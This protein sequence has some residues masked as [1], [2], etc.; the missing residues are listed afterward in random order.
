VFK[1]ESNVMQLSFED[2]VGNIQAIRLVKL[3]IH[4]AENDKFVRIPD[5][6]F[7]GP[8]GHGKTTLARIVAKYLD[9]K[10]IEINATIVRDP[11]QFR[12]YIVGPNAPQTGAIIFIDECH[13]LKNK[14]QT[15]LLSATENPRKL[16]TSYK[17]QIYRDS[18]PENISFIFA[19]TKRSQIISE[20]AG[21]LETVE[22]LEYSEDEKCEMVVKYMLRQHDITSTQLNGECIVD[23]ASRSREA[24]ALVKNCDKIIL[25]MNKRGRQ[26]TKEIVDETFEILGIDEFGLNRLDRKLLKLLASCGT[27]IGIETLGDLMNMPK[28][29]IKLEIEPYLLVNNFMARRSAGRMITKKGLKTVG[30]FNADA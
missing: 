20:L 24:R 30:T 3:L 28:R 19:T 23:I 27:P 25:N 6:A 13:A 12:S 5:M 21:R 4:A 16:H 7:L 1:N 29:D 17:D 15:N 14:V 22:F 11:F 2:F 26:L 10:L 8:S 9:R 18:L